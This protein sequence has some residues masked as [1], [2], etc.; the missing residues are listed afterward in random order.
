MRKVIISLVLILSAMTAEAQIEKFQALFMYKF[1]QNL[2]WPSDKE[3][4]NYMIGVI[5]DDG[6]KT[7]ITDLVKGRS[8]KGKPIEV[9]DYT[10][11]ASTG[12]YHLIFI[13]D[14]S[15]NIF[16]ATKKQAIKTATVLVTESSGLGQKGATINFITVGGALKFEMNETTLSASDVKASGSIKS[17]AKIIN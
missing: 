8:V 9:V 1:V 4:D 12:K 14:K 6:F 3:F 17:L 16:E 7:A 15:K 2:E 5:G 10:P 11:G 13:G